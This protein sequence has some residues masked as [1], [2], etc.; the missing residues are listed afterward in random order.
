MSKGHL[1]KLLYS[2]FVDFFASKYGVSRKTAAGSIDNILESIKQYLLQEAGQEGCKLVLK[3]FGTF[4]L[5]PSPGN[6][7]CPVD[8]MPVK[9][10]RRLRFSPCTE[11]RK[12]IMQ[13]DQGEQ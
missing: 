6:Y 1:K 7:F 11:F 5:L 8:D 12:S 10:G 4:K 13:E 3:N 9:Y 2:D